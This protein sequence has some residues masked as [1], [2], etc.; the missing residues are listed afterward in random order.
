MSNFEEAIAL[1]IKHEGGLNKNP[2]DLGGITKYGI[3]LRFLKTINPAA[4]DIS[5]IK[6][7]LDQAKDI[8]FQYFWIP[9]RYQDIKSQALANKLLDTAVNMGAKLAN[10]FLQESM[11]ILGHPIKI[12][13]ILGTQSISLVN[14]FLEKNKAE[15]LLR[16]YTL[17]QKEHYGKIVVVNKNQVE[18]LKGWFNR[19]NALLI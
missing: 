2:Y 7:E 11:Q 4:D 5:I 14:N 17:L 8:Y 6:M 13:G 18:F 10:R 12:D 15:N 16:I 19:A 1:V 9:N 3:S